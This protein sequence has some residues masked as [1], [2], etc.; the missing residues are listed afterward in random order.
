MPEVAQV[1]APEARC[2][3]HSANV[4][5]SRSLMPECLHPTSWVVGEQ[6]PCVL[7]PPS[8]ARDRRHREQEEPSS[9]GPP[10]VAVEVTSQRRQVS[11]GN[12]HS[13]LAGLHGVPV[14]TNALI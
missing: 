14:V 10:I 13:H 3:S 12:I 4:A 7:G 8:Q 6:D 5:D 1:D 2:T 9:L 11:G